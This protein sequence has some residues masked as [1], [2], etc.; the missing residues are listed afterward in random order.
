MDEIIATQAA[1]VTKHQKEIA[2]LKLTDLKKG[3]M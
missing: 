2:A 1:Q 3:L